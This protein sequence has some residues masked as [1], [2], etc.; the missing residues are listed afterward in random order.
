MNKMKPGNP[1]YESKSSTNTVYFIS[2]NLLDEIGFVAIQCEEKEL[3]F[4]HRSTHK[5]RKTTMD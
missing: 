2:A 4:F 5:N 1:Q 3:L